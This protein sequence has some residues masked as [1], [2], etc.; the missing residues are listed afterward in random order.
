MALGADAREADH[1]GVNVEVLRSECRGP[2]R[3]WSRG[4]SRRVFLPL[5]PLPARSVNLAA[6]S[7]AGETGS[8]SL[9]SPR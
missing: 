9:A 7:L 8:E 1:C 2:R 5:A 3:A 4:T 6:W